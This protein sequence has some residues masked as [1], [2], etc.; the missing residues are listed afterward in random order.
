MIR[1]IAA[2][3]LVCGLFG[4]STSH[5]VTIHA[6][7]VTLCLQVPEASRVQFAASTDTFALHEAVRDNDGCWLIKGLKNSEFRYFYLVDGKV[8]VPDCR[9]TEADDFG[10]VNC[11]YLPQEGRHDDT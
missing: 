8:F 3:F 9:F 2:V 5:Y 10:S 6:D 11:R 7:T 1:V 4:C